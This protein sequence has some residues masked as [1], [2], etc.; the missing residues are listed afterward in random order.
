VEQNLE[1][2]KEEKA[3]QNPKEEYLVACRQ[4]EVEKDMTPDSD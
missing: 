4:K 1:E 2:G 3:L